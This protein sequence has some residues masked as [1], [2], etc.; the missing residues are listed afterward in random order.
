[1]NEHFIFDLNFMR[2]SGGNCSCVGSAKEKEA[3]VCRSFT[4]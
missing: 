1:M 3:A 4:Q 2:R